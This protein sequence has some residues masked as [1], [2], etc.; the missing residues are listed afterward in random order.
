VLAVIGAGAATGQAQSYPAKP[1][2]FVVPFPPGG[3]LDIMARGIG[4]KLQGAWGQPVIVENKPGAGGGIGADFV[5]KSPGDGY[6]LLM[7]AVSTHAINPYLYAKIPYDPVKDFTPVTLVAQV[8]NVLVVNPSLP[9]KSV[10]E[11]IDHA[12]AKP[13]ALSFASGSTGSTG[14]LAGELF[15]TM[16]GVDMVHIPYKGA[17]AGMTD[18]LAGNIHLAYLAAVAVV[19]YVKA[20]KLRAL[21]VT[22]ERRVDAWPGV[23]AISEIVPGFSAEHWYGMWATPGTP[24]DII[25]RVNQAL[26]K[27]LQMPEVRDRILADGFVPTHSTPEEYRKRIA[28]DVAKWKDVVKRGNIKVD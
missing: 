11:L 12:K 24:V 27:V 28:S 16:A 8:P 26:A 18:L 23:P 2:H 6:M 25:G 19:P 13:G 5:A 4:G 15:K 1:I 10:K 21:G 14:H 9:V 20:G 22:T 3:P 17:G 7:G